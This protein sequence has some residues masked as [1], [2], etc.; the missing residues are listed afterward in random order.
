MNTNF[1]C[2]FFVIQVRQGGHPLSSYAKFPVCVRIRTCA[3][4][5]VRNISFPENFP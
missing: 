4:Q 3:Y 2:N 1:D 5:G